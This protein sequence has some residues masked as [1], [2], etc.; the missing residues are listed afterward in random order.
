MMNTSKSLPTGFTHIT[1]K[2]SSSE[3]SRNQLSVNLGVNNQNN[4]NEDYTEFDEVE[5]S[6]C[7][8]HGEFPGLSYGSHFELCPDCRGTG[9]EQ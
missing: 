7:H 4:M 3:Y 5:C 1:L 6:T 9:L 2:T 8:G